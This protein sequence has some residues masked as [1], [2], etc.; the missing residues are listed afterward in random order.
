MIN[1]PNSP[2]PAA[3]LVCGAN[4]LQQIQGLTVPQKINTQQ[5]TATGNTALLTASSGNPPA[6]NLTTNAKGAS[7]L[8]APT[9][10]TGA[11]ATSNGNFVGVEEETKD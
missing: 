7:V 5:N 3:A 6:L 1:L 10:L 4:T 8:G 11:N 2:L 9:A